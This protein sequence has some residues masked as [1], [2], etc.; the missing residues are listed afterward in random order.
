METMLV[1]LGDLTSLSALQSYELNGLRGNTD[2]LTEITDQMVKADPQ[3]FPIIE[4][5]PNA[6]LR[7]EA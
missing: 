1:R 7:L 4:V 3:A 2:R 5:K 6:L